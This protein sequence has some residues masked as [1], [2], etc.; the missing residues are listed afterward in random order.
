MAHISE[1]PI[2]PDDTS[3]SMV[4]RPVGLDQR[5]AQQTGSVAGWRRTLAW[6]C[7][8]GAAVFMFGT[9]ALLLIPDAPP[10]APVIPD[11]TTVAE[12]PAST[13]IP[14][15]LPTDAP[16]ATAIEVAAGTGI[17][18][19]PV[20]D[21]SRVEYILQT[22]VAQEVVLN[23]ISYDPFTVIKTDR[24]RSV[25]LDYTI[26]K[27]DT[28]DGISKRF[29]LKQESIA[30]CNDRRIIF[31]LR[32]GDVLT[33]PPSDGVCHRVLGTR[34]ETPN[35]LAQQYKVANVYD[36]IDFPLNNLYGRDP[37]SVLPGGLFMFIPGGE[38][39]PITWNPGYTVEKD[40]N[41]NVR[42]VT[43]AQG[44]AGSCGTQVPGA[45][46]AWG[47]PLP[48]GKW[49]R[50]FYAGHTG[51]DLSAPIGTPV[52]AANSGPVLFS[53]FS[54]WGYGETVVLSHGLFSTLYAHMS[55]RN[56]RCG[57]NLTVGNVVGLVGS[58]GNSTGP[59]LHFEIRSDDIPFNPS[60]MG[61][62]W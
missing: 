34:E 56:A 30:W 27:G 59:H 8:L 6:V 61:T 49:V 43:F 39:E 55:Q 22:P 19:I 23:G 48:S 33:I 53:G 37:D 46:A 20:L 17:Q 14:T 16:T 13:T 7:L 40:E 47:N 18:D 12:L 29:N 9:M 5:I 42:T 28:I 31:V 10:P 26:I 3:P 36:I 32:V 15:A 45:G 35:K 51:I 54:R 62:G 44:Q 41:G 38:A 50:G 21:V 60:G 52:F 2:Q 1:P 24:P 11:T 25:F 57:D 58:T 4:M